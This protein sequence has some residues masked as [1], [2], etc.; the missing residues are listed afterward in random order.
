[1]PHSRTTSDAAVPAAASLIWYRA[2]ISHE[3]AVAGHVHAI[4]R[5]FRDAISGL[6]DTSGMWL[7]ATGRAARVEGAATAVTS[8][9]VAGLDTVFFSPVSIAVVP[10][11]IAQYAAEPSPPPARE[12]AVLLVGGLDAWSGL[13][14]G[15]H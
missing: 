2:T 14:R 4:R 1:M 13:P 5:L 9:D 11:L 8:D 12:C 10:H 3:Q 7:F 15:A 6:I